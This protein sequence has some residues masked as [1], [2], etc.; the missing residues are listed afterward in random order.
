MFA[1][2]K[3]NTFNSFQSIEASAKAGLFENL[4]QN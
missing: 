1:Q 4:F 2:V 3:K